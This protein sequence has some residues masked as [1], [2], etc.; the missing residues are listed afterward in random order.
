MVSN[1]PSKISVLCQVIMTWSRR[2]LD[3]K[4]GSIYKVTRIY[5]DIPR[6]LMMRIS[7]FNDLCMYR[8]NSSFS[9]GF[10]KKELERKL[11]YDLSFQSY[12]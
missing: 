1:S 12:F 4:L 11:K 9:C 3:D 8:A 5:K 7:I 10:L 2:R 6:I